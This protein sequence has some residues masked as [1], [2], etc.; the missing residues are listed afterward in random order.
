MFSERLKEARSARRLTQLELANI[1][2]VSKATVSG[3]ERGANFP[4][5][6]TLVLVAKTLHT[7]TDY[8][9][10]LNQANVISTE[11]LSQQDIKRI[12]DLADAWRSK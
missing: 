2:G 10:G 12:K 1:V 9:L 5:V 8:L 6:S 4:S 11:G 7:S 3:W